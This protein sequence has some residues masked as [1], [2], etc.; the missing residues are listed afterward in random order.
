MLDRADGDFGR[1]LSLHKG[2]F[3]SGG[4]LW[5]VGGILLL[6]GF[7]NLA[8]VAGL[9]APTKG[10]GTGSVGFAAASFVIG[11]LV[12]LGPVLRWRQQAELFEGGLVWSRLTGTLRVRRDEVRHTE[13]ITHR[14]RAASYTEVVVHLQS[15]RELSME[16]LEHAEQLA[17][18]LSA[19]GRPMIQPTQAT[20]TSGW[21]P[22]VI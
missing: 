21:T 3:A 4:W 18:M 15:G 12:L 5:Y 11:A 16:G 10:G 6:S 13:L 20:A 17:N 7:A 9:L 2:T 14:G 19:Y 22:P 1:S 8:Q